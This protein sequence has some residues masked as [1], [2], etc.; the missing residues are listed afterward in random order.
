MKISWL[1]SEND[2][3]SFKFPE[4]FGFDVYKLSN[5]DDVDSKIDEL[6]KNNYNT[7]ILSNEIAGFSQK[8]NNEYIKNKNVE[9]I[10]S[11]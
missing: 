10:I 6:I 3:K 1:K 4:N 8:I 11:K 2:K 7:I 9:I 5:P